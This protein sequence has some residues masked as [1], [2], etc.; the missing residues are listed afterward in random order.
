MKYVIFI[1]VLLFSTSIYACDNTSSDE[2]SSVQLQYTD[3]TQTASDNCCDEFCFCNCCNQ[4]SLLGFIVE[5]NNSEN[6]SPR[7]M[8]QSSQNFS[9]Y[10]STHWQPPKI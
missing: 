4:I 3:H 5:P 2:C 6:Y 1:F 8:Y 7:I 9:G 10:F